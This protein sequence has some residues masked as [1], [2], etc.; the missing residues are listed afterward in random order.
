MTAHLAAQVHKVLHTKKERRIKVG[1][2]CYTDRR[3]YTTT[4]HLLELS[5]FSRVNQTE[6]TFLSR[7]SNCKAFFSLYTYLAVLSIVSYGAVAAVGAQAISTGASILTGLRV[8]LILLKLTECPI[9]TRTATAREGV[10][11]INAS[12]VIQ[13]GAGEKEKKKGKGFRR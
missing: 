8:T 3:N 9:K 7:S 6:P 4:S 12:P 11:I 2:K 1:C 10:D 5:I 13:T